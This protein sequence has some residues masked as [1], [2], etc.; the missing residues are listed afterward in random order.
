MPLPFPNLDDRSFQDLVDEV[1]ARVPA[2]TPEW[3]NP[4]VGDPGRTLVEL[5]AWLTDTLLYRVNLVPERQKFAFLRLLG[6]KMRAATAART[7]LTLAID[8]PDKTIAQTLPPRTLVKGARPFETLA[9]LTILP[10]VGEAYCKRRLTREEETA[11]RGKVAELQGLYLVKPGQTAVPYI[12]TPLFPGGR[13]APEGFD[14]VQGTVDHALWFA[15]LAPD[16][17]AM[18]K[19]ETRVVA[20]DAIRTTLGQSPSGGPQYLN[21]GVSPAM[22]VVK[23]GEDAGPRSP[24]H[25]AVEL[26][27]PDLNHAMAV[28]YAGLTVVTDTSNG[29]TTDGVLRLKLPGKDSFFAPTSNVRENVDAGT[30][31]LPPRLDDPKKAARLIAW[32]RL[33][34]TEDLHSLALNWAGL[35]AVQADQRVTSAGVIVGQ[36]T[37]MPD[38]EIKLPGGNLEDAT[39]RLQVEEAGRGF[40]RWERID[41]L[42]L[43][44]PQ[45]AVYTL[46][47]EAGIVRFGDGVRGKIPVR[48]ARIRIEIMR[49]GGG[50]AGN[51]AAGSLSAVDAK[52]VD[53]PRLN[54]F[55]PLPAKG[56]QDAETLD[57][58][59]KRIPS[60]FRHRDRVVTADDYRQLALA[61]PGVRVGRVEVLP[62]FKPHQRR[63]DVPGVV[64]V[65]VLPARAGLEAPYPNVDR[66]F[67]EA[68]YGFLESRKPLGVELYVIGCEYVQIGLTVGIVNPSGSE[69]VNTAVKEALQ[70]HLFALPPH[71]PHGAGWPLGGTV[72]ARELEIVVSRVEGVEGV[73][74]PNLFLRQRDGS[75]RLMP[76]ARDNA[77]VRLH[78]WQLPELVSVVVAAGNAPTELKPPAPKSAKEGIAIPVVPE[79]C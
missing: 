69:A 28:V 40:I 26:T 36:G 63:S 9:E 20:L 68:V 23:F 47:A 61:T 21:V 70:R 67:R 60:V 49:A 39:F 57:E 43:A 44:A 55:Q 34:P 33:R 62:R 64:S 18:A 46:D 38:L 35:N 45:Q 52:V 16:S 8:D 37:G 13:P 53:P 54:A 27:T 51:L 1:L 5:F 6:I 66:P 75:W 12:T 10:I 76:D 58:A 4:A 56:G 73:H 3:T 74:G 14:L 41:D 50:D 15:L 71:G 29:L 65:M 31:D 32:L 30:G 11:T 42:A 7:L 22:A 2:H 19:N 79:V 25:Y 17:N 72:R 78:P 59:L 24:I 77:A 48:G